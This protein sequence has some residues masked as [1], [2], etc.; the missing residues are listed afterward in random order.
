MT[1]DTNE[2]QFNVVRTF[3]TKHAA[4]VE[5]WEAFDGLYGRW[6]LGKEMNAVRLE[7]HRKLEAELKVLR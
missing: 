7:A 2:R 3:L 5:V 1:T 4:P 6:K